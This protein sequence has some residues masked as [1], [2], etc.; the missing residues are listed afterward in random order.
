M[1]SLPDTMERGTRAATRTTTLLPWDYLL[2]V[3]HSEIPAVVGELECAKVT[4]LARLLE[5]ENR[6]P[7]D[8]PLLTADQVAEKLQVERKWIYRHKDKLGAVELSR[9]NLRFPTSAVD[10]YIRRRKAASRRGRR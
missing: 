9:R 5:S 6:G 2:S 4:L 7:K 8:D 3:P 10:A 1:I